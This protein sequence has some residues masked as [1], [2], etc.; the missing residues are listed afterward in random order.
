MKT[1]FRESFWRDVR[2]I[3]DQKIIARI[4]EVIA[5]VEAAAR[6]SEIGNV[7][8][9]VGAANAYRIR[10]GGFRIGVFA[11]EDAVEFVRC[12]DRKDMYRYFPP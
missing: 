8:K 2:K 5:E 3:K 1:L 9:M 6:F 12:L 7:K 10:V 4:D 11:E